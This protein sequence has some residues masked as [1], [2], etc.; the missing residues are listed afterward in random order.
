MQDCI[1]ENNEI[2]RVSAI[3]AELPDGHIRCIADVIIIDDDG[4]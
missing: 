4:M 3:P 2:F 1:L